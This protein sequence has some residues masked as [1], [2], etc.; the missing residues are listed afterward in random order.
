MRLRLR[1]L[2]NFVT[3]ID[4]AITLLIVIV[5]VYIT[6]KKKK[7]NEYIDDKACIDEQ[8]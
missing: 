4:I 3:V 7:N 2:E 1:L 6:W 8:K 5:T